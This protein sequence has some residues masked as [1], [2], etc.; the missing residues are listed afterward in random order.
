M[1]PNGLVF[2]LDGTL[3][4]TLASLAESF[5]HA[6]ENSGHPTHETEDYRYFIGDGAVTAVER[7]L[8]VENR[9]PENI[10]ECVGHF[11][12]HYDQNWHRATIYPGVGELLEQLSGIPLAVLSNKDD[13][14]TRQC[15]DY[16]FPGVFQVTAGASEL[17]RHKPDPSGP[18]YIAGELGT[19]CESLWMIG[20]TAT[21]MKTAVATGMTPVGVIWGFRERDELANHGA[22]H[23]IDAPAD[24]LALL[25]S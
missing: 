22:I 5:N 10:A 9:S 6:L 3:L 20:D 23:I 15:I 19:G 24:L 14:F 13:P 4:D 8:P 11:R 21:D 18:E 12:D 25:D 16:F 7:A 1:K 17:V 2:D